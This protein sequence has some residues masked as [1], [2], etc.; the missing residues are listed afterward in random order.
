MTDVTGVTGVTDATGATMAAALPGPAWDALPGV[1]NMYASFILELTAAILLFAIRFSWRQRARIAV[2]AGILCLAIVVGAGMELTVGGHGG[3]GESPAMAGFLWLNLYFLLCAGLVVALLRWAFALAWVEALIV[4]TAGYAIQHTAFA[5]TSCLRSALGLRLETYD[6]RLLPMRLVVYVVVYAV[7]WFAAVRRFRMDAEKV[8]QAPLR[9]LFGIM[10]L[11]AM[12]VL[13]LVAEQWL[14]LPMAGRAM[15]SLYDAFATMLAFVVLLLAAHNDRLASD[16]AVMRQVDEL[17]AQHYEMSRE[18]IELV[19]T[20]FHDVR[21]GL[22]AL[23]RAAQAAKAAQV[24]QDAGLP[25]MP[26]VPMAS[27]DT[28]EDAIRTYDSIFDTGDDALDA[29]LT[30]KSLYCTAHGITLTAMADGM[31]LAFMERDDVYALFGNILDNAI[32][33]VLRLSDLE[34]RHIDLTVTR[35]GRFLTVE[36]Q[37]YCAGEVRLGTDGLPVTSKSD[38]RFHGLG[39]RSIARCVAGYGGELD[40]SAEAGV[41]TLSALIPVP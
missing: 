40:I 9:V 27:L 20:K 11:A 2:S 26:T 41:F 8:R 21:K 6:V 25:G 12:V 31:A 33:A 1:L 36:E 22:A 30:E 37:N 19:N 17:K 16:L 23:R 15:C 3:F 24:S 7:A 4:V 32:E 34:Q 18:A 14:G 5:L 28:M 10:A 39:T 13:N 38:R 29:V 35:T